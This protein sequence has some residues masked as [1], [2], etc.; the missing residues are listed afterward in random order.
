[1]ADTRELLQ[2]EYT[3][4]TPE[5]VTFGYDVAGIGNRFIGASAGQ[6]PAGHCT[7]FC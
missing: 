4:D 5:N 2:E 3:I 1:M 6:F 7:L